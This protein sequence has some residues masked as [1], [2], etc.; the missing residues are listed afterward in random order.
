MISVERDSHQ[1][2][3]SFIETTLHKNY[4]IHLPIRATYL[5]FYTHN[6]T[7]S[8]HCLYQYR[9]VSTNTKHIVIMGK[10]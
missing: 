8:I 5:H 3:F 6:I 7:N 10:K 1:L 9:N 4:S 2:G